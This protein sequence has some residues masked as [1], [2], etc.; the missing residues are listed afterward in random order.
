MRIQDI[1]SCAE[2]AYCG[3][4]LASPGSERTVQVLA[5]P[6]IPGREHIWVR[7]THEGQEGMR[8]RASRK[9]LP[10]ATVKDA[11]DT[12]EFHKYTDKAYQAMCELCSNYR[13]Y[14]PQKPPHP[15]PGEAR[16]TG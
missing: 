16:W 6:D 9:K 4:D 5:T 1:W 14:I 2:L 12:E 7:A 10:L 8:L 13:V 11:N 3:V 15:W